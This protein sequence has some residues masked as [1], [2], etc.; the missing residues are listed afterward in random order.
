MLALVALFALLTPAL[1]E[2]IHPGGNATI[3]LEARVPLMNNSA[4][5]TNICSN[6]SMQNWTI[7]KGSTKVKLATAPFCLDAG[8]SG[9][10]VWAG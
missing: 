4:V 1:A 6:N 3:C 7:T 5:F 2:F 10:R 9:Y 8:A